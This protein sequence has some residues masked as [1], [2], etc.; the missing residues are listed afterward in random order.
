MSLAISNDN[1][2]DFDYY[3]TGISFFL[4]V[5]M[6]ICIVLATTRY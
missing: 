2:T 5:Y 3:I 6:Y 4:S 1:L